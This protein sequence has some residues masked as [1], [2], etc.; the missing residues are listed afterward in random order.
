MSVLRT[1]KRALTPKEKPSSR[2]RPIVNIARRIE[3]G[4]R[5]IQTGEIVPLMVDKMFEG[6]EE[7]MIQNAY[8]RE[9]YWILYTAD[10]YMNGEQLRDTFSP[11]GACPPKMLYTIC[12][13]VDNKRGL[14]TNE[15]V[16]PKDA[17]TGQ[18]GTGKISEEIAA[19]SKD[20]PIIY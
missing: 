6:L 16:L 7:C 13:K 15:W 2:R 14:L 1:M 17:P 10:W 19:A 8:R 4:Q 3:A 5:L 18:V 20:I 9:P 12:W 11:Y